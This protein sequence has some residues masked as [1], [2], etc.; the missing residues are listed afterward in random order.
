MVAFF[1]RQDPADR[2]ANT[3][4]RAIAEDPRVISVSRVPGT[5]DVHEVTLVDGEEPVTFSPRELAPAIVAAHGPQQATALNHAVDLVL[6][7]VPIE[8]WPEASEALMP[9]V[10][11]DADVARRGRGA[12]SRALAPFLRRVLTVG[13]D[14]AS[15]RVSQRDVK[16]WN[17]ANAALWK[18][19]LSNLNRHAPDAEALTGNLEGAFLIT[20]PSGRA[21]SWLLAPDA[22]APVLARTEG[23]PLLVA[24][25]R[26]VLIVVGSDSVEALEALE[27]TAHDYGTD[28]RGLSPVPYVVEAG[29]IE[30]WQPPRHHPLRAAVHRNAVAQVQVEYAG[31]AERLA[32][33]FAEEGRDVRVSDVVVYTHAETEMTCC[34]WV[35]ELSDQLLPRTD[36]IGFVSV[37]PDAEARP[38]P[39]RVDWD[40]V[41]E[42]VGADL[43][44]EEG[45]LPPLY[46]VGGWPEEHI[47]ELRERAHHH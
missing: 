28:P 35:R 3:L 43:A 14:V 15:V 30:P 41:A 13:T 10:R 19:A 26:D 1:R 5:A 18:R 16:R 36:L 47:E 46:H 23:T 22:L 44:E 34:T 11:S 20:N 7:P 38:E 21:A 42:V 27:A 6:T 39:F 31:Q 33:S 37:D 32:P 9:E 40:V 12:Y 8:T 4:L 17:V 2:I 24:P 29:A 25:A 45:H